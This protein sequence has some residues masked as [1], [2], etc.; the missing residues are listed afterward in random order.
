MQGEKSFFIAKYFFQLFITLIESK[1]DIGIEV[2][3][4]TFLA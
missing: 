3:V 1:D 2:I 4:E